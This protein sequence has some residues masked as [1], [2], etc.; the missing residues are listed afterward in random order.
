MSFEVERGEFVVVT[1]RVG[2]GKTTLL[3]TLLGLLPAGSGEIVW[4]GAA[5]GDPASFF[6]PPRTAYV[7]QVPTVFSDSLRENI[8]LG[9]PEQDADLS[10]AVAQAAF[11]EDLRGMEAGLETAI[12]R[13]GMRLSGGQ[14]QRVAAARMFVREADLLVFDDISSALD[15]RTEQRLWEGVFANPKTACLVV[16]HRR[17]ALRRA[18]KIIVLK[19][20]RMEAVGSLAALLET[21][22]EMRHLWQQE[23]APEVLA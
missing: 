2:S 8:L 15:V 13:Q 23:E 3:R 22:E 17:A 10:K 19:E 20:G 4:N 6:V 12:G 16:S 14:V 18:D 9:L 7:P 1:G 5:V 11:S 21:C